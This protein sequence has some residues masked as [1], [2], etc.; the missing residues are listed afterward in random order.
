MEWLNIVL[1]GESGWGWLALA[2]IL[3]ALDIVAPGF[4]LVWFAIAS[5]ITGALLFA[6]PLANPWPLVV[7]S[8]ASVL[9]LVIGRALWGSH[10]DIETDKPLLNQRG[11][12]LVG[13]TF[14]LSEPIAGGRGRMKVGDTVWTVSGPS[15]PAGELVRVKSA[16]GTI[17]AVE[18]ADA[19]PRF[20][21]AG[22]F[23]A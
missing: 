8:A 19:G 4:Y 7:F 23:F 6:V 15:L 12:Q 11:R 13:Q 10:R 14:I 20:P 9:S 22:S 3:F 1:S 18:A 21:K 17:L 2:A 5:T 16:E